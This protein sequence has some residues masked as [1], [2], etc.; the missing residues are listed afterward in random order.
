MYFCSSEALTKLIL[1]PSTN[2]K[3]TENNKN[4]VVRERSQDLSFDG[5]I[6]KRITGGRGARSSSLRSAMWSAFRRA[7]SS[8]RWILLLSIAPGSA[9]KSRAVSFY[10]IYKMHKNKPNIQ[11]IQKN[12]KYTKTKNMN[13]AI[14]TYY[15]VKVWNV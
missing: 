5:T 10:K 3:H 9:I 6:V 11:N 12:I 7:F 13:Y 2:S 1:E 15:K 8:R 4:S 14:Y